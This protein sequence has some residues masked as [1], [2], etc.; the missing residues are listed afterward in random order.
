MNIENKVVTVFG[1]VVKGKKIGR[2]INFPTANINYLGNQDIKFGVYGCIVR[3]LNK[4]FRG[5]LNVGVRPTINDGDSVS[6]EVNICKFDCDIYGEDIECDLIFYVRPEM[7]FKN[8]ES[9]KS[10]IQKD[11]FEVRDKFD[12]KEDK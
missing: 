8:V 2:T 5:V 11:I 6:Y 12:I 9:L 10:Q 3:V 7:K 1:K 4:E